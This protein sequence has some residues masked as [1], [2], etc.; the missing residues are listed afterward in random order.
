MASL[1]LRVTRGLIEAPADGP[2]EI[3]A[4]NEVNVEV[5]RPGATP[6]EPTASWSSRG[7]SSVPA[8][9]GRVIVEV[10]ADSKVTFRFE[11]LWLED[12]TRKNTVRLDGTLVLDCA[13]S[14]TDD[15]VMCER[16]AGPARP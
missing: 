2:V 7:G 10:S 3:R 5:R 16:G 11:R 12:R 4:G 13:P 9:R 8:D 15:A 14:T 6:S 1:E